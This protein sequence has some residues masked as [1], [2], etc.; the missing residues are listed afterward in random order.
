MHLIRLGHL[1]STGDWMLIITA[2]T[3]LFRAQNYT[4]VRLLEA[5]HMFLE[6]GQLLRRVLI[7]HFQ[8]WR[9]WQR[10]CLL[11]SQSLPGIDSIILVI[12]GI[13]SVSRHKNKDRMPHSLT[14]QLR[15]AQ[16]QTAFSTLRVLADFCTRK[17]QSSRRPCISCSWAVCLLPTTSRLPSSIRSGQLCWGK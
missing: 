5:A 10:A 2:I 1:V 4:G 13:C 6:F 3:P 9:F 15:M 17:F 14:P 16:L 7:F 11:I 12:L 8:R